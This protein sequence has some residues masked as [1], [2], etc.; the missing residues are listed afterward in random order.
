MKWKHTPIPEIDLD[1]IREDVRVNR[2]ERLAF[3]RFYA[4]WVRDH[5]NEQVF[6]QQ[7][8]LIDGQ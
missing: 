4:E 2:A 6:R 5:P 7:K 3:A 8:D 1:E